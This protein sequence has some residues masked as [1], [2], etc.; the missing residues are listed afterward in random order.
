MFWYLYGNLRHHFTGDIA[1]T[2]STSCFGG[3]I[4][5]KYDRVE[6]LYNLWLQNLDNDIQVLTT[7]TNQVFL[8]AQDMVYKGMLQNGQGLQTH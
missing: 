6:D 1:Y 7:A 2:N 8:G 3:P 5:P 4:T